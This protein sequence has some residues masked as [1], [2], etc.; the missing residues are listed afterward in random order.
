MR[1]IVAGVVAVA[2]G[3]SA[4]VA[5]AQE[6]RGCGDREDLLDASMCF[7]DAGHTTVACQ[8]ARLEEAVRACPGTPSFFASQLA[9][10]VV[11]RERV[12]TSP[13]ASDAQ[14][15]AGA[16]LA[17]ATLA[18]HRVAIRRTLSSAFDAYCDPT[19]NQPLDAC[20]QSLAAIVAPAPAPSNATSEARARVFS[21]NRLL[22]AL[23]DTQPGPTGVSQ[24]TLVAGLA[25]FLVDR[26]E[27]EVSSFAIES[28]FSDLCEDASVRPLFSSTCCVIASSASGDHEDAHRR[29]DS[30]FCGA[31]D[32]SEDA[33]PEGPP[34][35]AALHESVR[36]D[37]RDLPAALLKTIHEKDPSLGC[38]LDVVYAAF[39]ALAEGSDP[40]ITLTSMDGDHATIRRYGV[41]ANATP[42]LCEEP[43]RQIDE[44]VALLQ[45][46]RTMPESPDLL[47]QGQIELL[48][49]RLTALL[50]TASYPSPEE[51]ERLRRTLR[52]A[53]VVVRGVRDLSAEPSAASRLLPA[54]AEASLRIAA[55]A[56]TEPRIRDEIL[57]L[58]GVLSAFSQ[59]NYP[60]AIA[61][62]VQMP[63]VR[64]AL[65]RL[66]VWDT[67]GR[68]LPP[69]A[70]VAAASSADEVAAA[71]DRFSAPLGSWRL[72]HDGGYMSLTGFVGVHGSYE[73]VVEDGPSIDGAD[74]D[75]P[76]GLTLAPA[77]MLGL[78]FGTGDRHVRWGFFVSVLDL[79]ALASARLTD[80]EG[81]DANAEAAPE[82]GVAQVFS[83]G[84]Y[85]TLGLDAPFTL[86]AGC[87]YVPALR[88]A[89]VDTA[90][91]E[92][93]EIDPLSVVR[94]G[95]FLAVD[96]TI[97]PIF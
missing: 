95:A 30:A 5:L 10:A 88:G 86:A 21:S 71:L 31:E 25:Q 56:V 97:L 70:E 33:D 51:L 78:D 90:T 74:S 55:E 65:R 40:W 26:A 39:V 37:I 81:S 96:V 19:P 63:H 72:K 7:L 60:R 46:V 43:W 79:G 27:D 59:E 6:P 87:S 29:E 28:L 82:I 34:S 62:L 38:G 41:L 16:P 47:A 57:T 54:I 53:M 24:S 80:E 14:V 44:L 11:A 49:D 61:L 52:H 66:G 89:I 77:L 84:L 17:Y 93:T 12:R 92:R 9:E 32:G 73:L 35:I 15:P 42:A 64:R 3:G 13:Q 68:I 36:Q 91:I 8:G 45:M 76:N 2:V 69:M 20:G 58:A 1:R 23:A 83:P 67:V 94:C 48:L 18:R 75:V 4:A 50:P 22:A 85:M